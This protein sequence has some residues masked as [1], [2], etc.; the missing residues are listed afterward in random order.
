MRCA[1]GYGLA[2]APE[3]YDQRQEKYSL[4][5]TES[6]VRAVWPSH[7]LL[8][9]AFNEFTP[10]P[11]DPARLLRCSRRLRESPPPE[12]PY[13]GAGSMRRA[14]EKP[15]GAARLLLEGGKP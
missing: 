8:E 11:P 13:P 15:M 6:S 12:P 10:D 9:D 3:L 5:L 7:D 14:A 4:N 2:P 1:P